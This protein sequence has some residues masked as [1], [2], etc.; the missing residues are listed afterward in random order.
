MISIHTLLGDIV[1]LPCSTAT[2]GG[3]IQALHAFDSESYPLERTDA[4]P[5]DGT[6]DWMTIILPSAPLPRYS[7][8]RV[9][10]PTKKSGRTIHV[11]TFHLTPECF[12]A[13]TLEEAPTERQLSI[14]R[15]GNPLTLSIVENKED[16]N[17]M[18]YGIQHIY[19]DSDPNSIHAGHMIQ[20]YC[21]DSNNK[22]TELSDL[23]N[24]CAHSVKPDGSC[25]RLKPHVV[26]DILRL[27]DVYYTPLQ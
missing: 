27:Y 15:N 6:T 25:R 9:S 24:H 17:Y 2:R 18:R 16:E 3:V 26:A 14:G 19:G 4:V 10:G 13:H 5:M 12:E 22:Y 21:V 1:E 7:G 23:V 11:Y 20:T 8:L